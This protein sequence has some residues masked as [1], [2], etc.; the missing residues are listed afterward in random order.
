VKGGFEIQ[1]GLDSIGKSALLRQYVSAP[2]HISKPWWD[3]DL[4]IV[5]AINS[6]AGLFAG[7]EI[8]TTLQVDA[9]A[10]LLIT[11]PSASRAYRMPSGAAT[12]TQTFHVGAGAWLEV[13]PSIFIPHAGSNYIQHTEVQLE[14]GASLL[15]FETIAP[16]RVA[17]GE[18]WQFAR[19]QNRFKLLIGD[20]LIARETWSLQPESQT[21]RA[22]RHQFPDACHATCY[23][24]GGD[25]S[26]SLLTELTN[27]HQPECWVGCTKLDAPSAIALRLVASDNIALSKTASELRRILHKSF[28][29]RLPSLRRN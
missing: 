28:N 9:G 16:G 22:I 25:F 11:S 19:M 20:R 15:W 6:T 18:S 1:C 23:A 29:R 4:L 14:P 24:V 2:M 27:L 8:R 5:N 21:V 3:G 13:L 7:D 26:D 10:Q 12:L 17:H